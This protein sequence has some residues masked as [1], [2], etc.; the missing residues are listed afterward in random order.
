LILLSPPQTRQ[1]P[2]VETVWAEEGDEPEDPA[3]PL[4]LA[5]VLARWMARSPDELRRQLEDERQL[6]D[7]L[8]R[9]AD[10]ETAR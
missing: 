10:A 8:R 4:V 9:R 2:C 1:E 6:D 5:R 7:L 3:T